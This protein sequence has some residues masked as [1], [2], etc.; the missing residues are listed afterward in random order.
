M[1]LNLSTGTYFGLDDVG[2]RMWT[3]LV[4]LGSPDE[5]IQAMLDEYDVEEEA[6]RADLQSLIRQLAEKGLVKT[7]A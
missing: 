6:L 5:V 2:T 3:L 1:I 7:H 4:K